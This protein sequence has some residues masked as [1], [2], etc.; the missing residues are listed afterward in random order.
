[1]GRRPLTA[2]LVAVAVAAAFAVVAGAC[3][4]GGPVV[5]RNERTGTVEWKR[6]DTL[7]CASLSV[8]VDYARPTGPHL[9]L[10]LAR[11]PAAGPSKGVLFT[12]PGGPGASGI[13]LLRGAGDVFPAEIRN[14]FDLVSW[15][16]RG[17]GASTPVTCLDNLD[18]FFAVNRDPHTA[19]QVAQN[20]DATR[21]FVDACKRNSGNLLPFM[22]TAAT[23]RDLDSIRAAIGAQQINYVG[24][25]YG[26]FIGASYAERFP[27]RVRAMVLDG[28]VDPARSFA[29]ST[30]DQA[31]G[32]DDD[33]DAFLAH[34]RADDNC[35]FAQ[36]GDPAAA[37][38]DLA[39][40]IAAEPIPAT[41][42]GEHRTLGPGEFDLG[43]ASALYAGAPGY[44]TLADALAQAG[45]GT[46]DA[47]L[48]LSDNYTGRQNGGKY[49]N[50][51]AVFYATGCVD[52]PA[53]P[54]VAAVQRLAAQV[55]KVAPRL[56][57][58]SVWLA[59][60]CT[61][62]PVPAQGN[63]A[64]IRATGA[65]P[66]LVV[67]TTHDPAT[68]YVWAQSLARELASGVLLTSD[69][70]SHTSYGHGD[71]CVDANT[72]RYLLELRVP[73]AGTRCA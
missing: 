72:D 7:E 34:C 18:A 11:L 28:V 32:F 69:A 2:L 10:A 47:L 6:C 44:K 59:L 3:G 41:V 71:Q 51:T 29:Q 33:L 64:P 39:T 16:P 12:N 52:G 30:I 67:G 15:D 45:R 66:I 27:K 14:S 19:A 22:S 13:D 50:E 40:T 48:A 70:A 8:P 55:A 60:P 43:V 54:T 26:T 46:G 58:S 9:T 53:P 17:V 56:G 23:V 42:D 73:A 5:L 65:P 35:S 62:W 68:P 57:P 20:V 4:A 38:D 25:S 37:Y 21:S 31:K 61:F 1:M 24:F 63:A 36:G 49:S